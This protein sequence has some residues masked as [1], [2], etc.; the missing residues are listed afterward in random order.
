MPK[1][2]YKE[3]AFRE[4]SL[5]VIDLV[6][7]VIEEY[8][9]MG[10]DL[11]LRQLYYQLVARGYIENSD[12]S[13]KRVGELINNAR[14]AGL[15]DWH[16]ITDRTRNM[17]SRSHWDS[18][19]QII[20]SAINQYFIDLREGQPCYVEVWVEKEALIEVVGK[21]CEKLDVP[22]FA[23]R[24]YVSQ[25]EMWAAAQR[26][27]GMEQRHERSIILHLGDHDPSG[28]DMT[29]DIQDRLSMFGSSV[30]VDRIAL[31]FEQVERY[32]PP[33]NPAKI[34]DSRCK[35]YIEEYGRESW[36]LDALN[37][38]I[39]SDLIT[40]HVDS[41]TDF[42]LLHERRLR[43]NREKATM[44]KYTSMLDEEEEEE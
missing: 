26:F 39:I 35:A 7:G 37:P 1:I 13:Y 36:E 34:T 14:L 19:G 30:Y 6:N 33:P 4:H 23:C 10:Y 12:R 25:S 8:Q 42:K 20:R 3:V 41:L 29:R 32:T 11:T 21:A 38:T 17:R 15:I 9:G 40:E 24:G 2:A 16:A 22:Y 44:E 31:T 43:L 28:V 27:I 5:Q 18:P